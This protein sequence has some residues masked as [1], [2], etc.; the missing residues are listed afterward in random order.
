[1]DSG[2]KVAELDCRYAA[3]GIWY[4]LG[5]SGQ[6]TVLASPNLSSG[7]VGVIIMQSWQTI[8]TIKTEA[9]ASLCVVTNS[10]RTPGLMSFGR[11]QRQDARD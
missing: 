11:E 9:L 8:K 3:F 1:M 4:Y 2:E 6:K 5:L 7:A 10:A